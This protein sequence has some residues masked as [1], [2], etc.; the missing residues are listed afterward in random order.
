VRAGVFQ[1]PNLRRINLIPPVPVP[2]AKIFR[3]TPDPNQNYMIRR[4]VPRVRQT[5]KHAD[6]AEFYQSFAKEVGWAAGV[7][8]N[9]NPTVIASVSEA[10]HSAASRQVDAADGAIEHQRPARKN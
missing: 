7:T 5:P 9:A 6:D 2:F 10:I 4:P 3:F 1:K 8:E